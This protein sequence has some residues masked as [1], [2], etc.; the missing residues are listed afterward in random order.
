MTRLALLVVAAALPAGGGSVPTLGQKWAPYQKGYGDVRPARI[1]NGGDPTGLVWHV[2]WTGWGERRA[3]GH[4]VAYFVWPGLGVADGS[5]ATPAVVVAYDLGTCR[6][7]R[8]YRKLE[9]FFPRYGGSFD[10]QGYTN[11]CTGDQPSGSPS[12]RHC[13]G[14]AFRSPPGKARNIQA[15]GVP[16][17]KARTLVA[18]SP[19]AR[20]L[21]SGGRF[22]YAGLFCGSEGDRTLGPPASF[23]CSR[24]RVTISFD[25]SRW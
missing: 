16:C 8:A 13:A 24:G 14:V 6:G 17:R 20:Y 25:V 1:F 23:E 10:A 19:W 5:T 21:H 7:K 11:I 9:W 3:V 15:L 22:R 4:G 18:R 12:P 2:R